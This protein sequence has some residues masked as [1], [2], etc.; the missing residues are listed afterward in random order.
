MSYLCITSEENRSFDAFADA[1]SHYR[2][3]PAEEEKL[4]C[5]TENACPI[6]LLRSRN[7]EDILCADALEEKFSDEKGITTAQI[8]IRHWQYETVLHPFPIAETEAFSGY[9]WL[10]RASLPDSAVRSVEVEGK[11][12]L[13][14]EKWEKEKSGFPVVTRYRADGVTETGEYALLTLDPWAYRRLQKRTLEKFKER[15][16]KNV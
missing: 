16:E 2:S 11:G 6:P 12:W 10:D 1:L 9:L 15:N 14:A 5:V 13:S 4:L 7:G 3:L 8:P